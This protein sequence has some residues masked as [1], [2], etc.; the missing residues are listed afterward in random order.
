MSQQGWTGSIVGKLLQRPLLVVVLLVA[1]LFAAGVGASRLKVDMSPEVFYRESADRL[2]QWRTHEAH[3]GEDES[4]IVLLA[5]SEEGS[6]LDEARFEI[7]QKLAQDIE[8]LD[9]VAQVQALSSAARVNPAAF[10]PQL[11]SED[12]QSTAILITPQEPNGRVKQLGRNIADI[13]SLAELGRGG[14]GLEF[15]FAGLP[16][17]RAAF[18]ETSIV[19]QTRLFPLA[20]LS[21]GLVLALAFRS[22]HGLLIPLVGAFVPAVFLA[23]IL[24]AVGEP[25]GLLNQVYFT[26]IPALAIADAVHLLARYHEE[27]TPESANSLEQRRAAVTRAVAAVGRACFLTSMTSALAF[28][29]LAAAE[30]PV[31]RSFGVWAG[32]GMI[33]AYLSFIL[34]LPPLLMWLGRK[35]LG[36]RETPSSLWPDATR[37]SRL[38]LVGTLALCGLAWV[39]SSNLEIDGRVTGSLAPE[40][41][42]TLAGERVDRE[43]GGLLPL[44]VDLPR[45]SSL[46]VEGAAQWLKGR[47]EVR[48]TRVERDQERAR[49]RLGVVDEGVRAFQAFRDEV[50]DELDARDTTAAPRLVGQG[51]VSYDAIDTVVTDMRGGILLILAG[52]VGATL[53]VVGFSRLFFAA[54]L[55]N[56]IPLV[57]GGAFM[58]LLGWDLDLG[59]IVIFAIALGITVDDTIHLLERYREELA[60][61]RST[62]DA[63]ERAVR[64]SGR[65]IFVT[66]ACLAFGFGLQCLSSIPQLVVIGG[67]GAFLVVVA[68]LADLVVLP[69]ALW[70]LEGRSSLRSTDSP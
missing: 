45:D 56:L 66:T 10:V 28:F 38:K 67:L 14:S 40:H 19:D 18:V 55:V 62:G 22:V 51:V 4:P 12:Q 7:L 50:E 63:L 8:A 15:E 16:A 59:S 37:W 46:D 1:S 42:V 2:A 33:G 44:D 54:A 30:T 31:V 21:I 35:P 25:L 32:V 17:V 61:G 5:H 47:G 70:W 3:W 41:P 11:L 23:G 36:R 60:E 20:L 34:W 27:L 52:I 57:A 65:A 13:R 49:I 64:C 6:V 48:W 39:S 58:A 29:A 53:M 68:M 26:L 43:L 69:A 24:G 9:A